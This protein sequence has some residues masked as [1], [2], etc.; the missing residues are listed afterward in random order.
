LNSNLHNLRRLE[1]SGAS[2]IEEGTVGQHADLTRSMQRETIVE[3]Q[4][5]A[6]STRTTT[7]R[8][9]PEEGNMNNG[10]SV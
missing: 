8:C 1:E 3:P 4:R 6:A 9:E 10:K 7:P 5:E 2:Q